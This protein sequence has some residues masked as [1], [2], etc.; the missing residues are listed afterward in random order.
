MTLYT[1]DGLVEALEWANSGVGADANACVWLAY[2]RWL[3][4]QGV[5]VPESGS[6]AAAALD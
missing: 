3:E 5:P 1:V 6:A 2:L 4:T